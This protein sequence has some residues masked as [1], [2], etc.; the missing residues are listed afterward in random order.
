MNSKKKEPI[1]YTNLDKISIEVE[2]AKKT[3]KKYNWPV[4]DVTKKIC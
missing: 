3:F 4:I 1:N 2:K